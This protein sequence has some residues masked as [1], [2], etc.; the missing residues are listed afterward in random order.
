MPRRLHARADFSQR[1]VVLERDADLRSPTRSVLDEMHGAGGFH[2]P[3]RERP[4]GNH[5]P[6]VFVVNL[7][8]PFQLLATDFRA[9]MQAFVIDLLH[10]FNSFHETRK[11]LELRPLIIDRAE[12][13]VDFN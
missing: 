5:S 4:P 13:S 1:R 2:I 8:V 10:G 12:G 7:G 9:P 6:G 11:L 3:P